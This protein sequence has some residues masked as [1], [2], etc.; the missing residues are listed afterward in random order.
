MIRSL[1][2]SV[3]GDPVFMK[4]VNGWLTLFWVA[5]AVVAEFTGWV[6]GNGYISRL[7]EVALVL[8]SWSAWQAA[9]V[10]VVQQEQAE[11]NKQAAV[12]AAQETAKK[13]TEK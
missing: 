9:R 4:R 7:S 3:Q 10:E 13:E 12:V 2:A 5:L 11:K 1:W 6:N 8:G